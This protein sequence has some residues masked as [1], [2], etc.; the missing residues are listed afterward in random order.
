MIAT[1]VANTTGDLPKIVVTHS[2]RP[3]SD[4]EACVTPEPRATASPTIALLR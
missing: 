4:A 3:P 2:G 1:T